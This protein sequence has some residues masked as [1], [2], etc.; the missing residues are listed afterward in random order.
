MDVVLAVCGNVV[1]QN[2]VDVWNIETSESDKKE[3]CQ[4]S[5][6]TYFML[7]RLNGISGSDETIGD[8]SF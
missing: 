7:H 5:S 1:V 6:E 2:Y 8:S 4:Q 3:Y